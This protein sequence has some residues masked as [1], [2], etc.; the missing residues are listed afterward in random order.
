M[1]ALADEATPTVEQ[2][3]TRVLPGFAGF[4]WQRGSSIFTAT[5]S[6]G[7]FAGQVLLGDAVTGEVRVVT[8]D[9]GVK[10]DPYSWR[11]PE[12][13]GAT[14]FAAIV[15]E[16][17]LAIYVDLGGPFFERVSLL[18]LPKGTRMRYL[19]SP[20]PF[21]AGGR[22]FITLSI[23]DDPGSFFEDVG[24]SEIWVYGI[25]DGPNRFARRFD[26]GLPGRVRHEAEAFAGTDEIFLY[27]NR[28]QHASPL[29]VAGF[30]L[31]R[32]RTGMQP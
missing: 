14:A 16:S 6:E 32:V 21:L 5:E 3:I 10:F 22:S 11:A 25:G 7:P 1:I 29:G 9:P 2:D 18:E 12:Y 15:D 19:Q 4:R 30:D 13:G 23:A 27:Y 20:E 17:D 26:D 28:R 24:E 8:D 31:I